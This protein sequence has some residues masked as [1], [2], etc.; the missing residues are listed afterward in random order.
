MTRPEGEHPVDWVEGVA[1]LI[2]ILILALVMSLNDWQREKKFKSLSKKREERLV[3]VIRDGGER[4][5]DIRN[6]VVGDVVLIEPGEVIPCDGVFLSG[7]N[8]WCGESHATGEPDAI[9]KLPFHECTALRDKRLAEVDPDGSLGDGEGGGGSRR[10]LNVSGLALLGRTDCFVVSGS[11]VIEGIGSYLVITVGEMS[12][13]GRI[14]MGSS[15]VS[16]YICVLLTD[17]TTTQLKHYIVIRRTCL[18]S[19][20]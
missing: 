2:A 4:I 7:H 12:F 9:K 6:V 11:K 19:S 10:N 17:K 15:F 8:V 16:S 5:I 14:M 18:C 13:S 1:I 20:S 3:K